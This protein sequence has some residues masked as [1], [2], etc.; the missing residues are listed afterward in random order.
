MNSAETAGYPYF[1][2]KDFS[3]D[4]LIRHIPHLKAVLEMKCDS[5]N[6]VL[7]I[8]SYE[9][10]SAVFFLQYL[11]LSHV[12]CID[13]W[14]ESDYEARFDKNLAP[15]AG[16]FRKLKDYSVPAIHKLLLEKE[17]YDVIYIDGG[18]DRNTVFCDTVLSWPLLKI[19]GILI[20]D[21]WQWEKE[22]QS[23]QRPEHAIDLF[24]VLF[25]PCLRELHRDYQ[26]IAEKMAEWPSV[27][28]RL[29]IPK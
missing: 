10:R 26:L 20:W 21:D 2:G 4:W 28:N 6:M 27:P 9:G 12:T 18:H 8:G 25:R 24:Y 23:E 16:R 19:G 17:S 11:P 22:L 13:C 5:P 15:F 14:L 3:S 7:E 1:T 29:N